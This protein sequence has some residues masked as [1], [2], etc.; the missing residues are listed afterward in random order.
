MNA[1]VR[2]SMSNTGPLV[3]DPSVH[4]VYSDNFAG[5]SFSQGNITLTFAVNRADHTKPGG[6]AP[7]QIVGR[8]VLPITTA[9]ILHENLGQVLNE[10]ESK[11]V[12]KKTPM[13]GIVQ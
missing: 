4:E 5:V 1:I 7:R 12:I 6:P 8:L 11:G 13:F 10:L 3:E 9:A 2:E